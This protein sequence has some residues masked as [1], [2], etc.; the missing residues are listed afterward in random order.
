PLKLD[1]QVDELKTES[2]LVQNAPFERE[3][4]QV[5]WA[6]RLD[7]DEALNSAN[8]ARRG[9]LARTLNDAI[10]RHCDAKGSTVCWPYS[11]A[12]SVKAVTRSSTAGWVENQLR[13]L[14]L[15]GL[16]I[17]MCDAD[18]IRGLSAGKG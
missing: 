5:A 10:R 17:I 8:T 18:L 9:L 2:T 16:A 1:A 13:T 4:D 6:A 12:C 15:N 11:R 3:Q 7:H 14:P